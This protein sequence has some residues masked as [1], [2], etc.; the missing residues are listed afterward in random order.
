MT[1]PVR[2]PRQSDIFDALDHLGYVVSDNKVTC[3]I[4]ADQ[5]SMTLTH[6]SEKVEARPGETVTPCY[7]DAIKAKTTP[8]RIL[9]L[10]IPHLAKYPD[11]RLKSVRF[12][13]C[14]ANIEDCYI[15]YSTL[16]ASLFAN[17]VQVV[18][19]VDENTLPVAN[20]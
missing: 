6:R 8:R 5:D 15:N 2:K 3:Y 13:E 9:S 4:V 14:E 1:I 7:G 20:R 19:E 16:S 11:G 18:R 17:K 12:F 10:Q